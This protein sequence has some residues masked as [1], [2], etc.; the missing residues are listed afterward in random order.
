[1]AL[2]GAPGFIV[3]NVLVMM[4]KVQHCLQYIQ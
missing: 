2:G 4:G 1:V 3:G